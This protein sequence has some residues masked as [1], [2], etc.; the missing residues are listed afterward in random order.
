MPLLRN[1]KRPGRKT[2]GNLQFFEN[3]IRYAW[4]YYIKNKF[5]KVNSDGWV[6][7]QLLKDLK[8]RATN[9]WA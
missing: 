4:Y 5:K 1:F 3:L 2:K 9:Q 8:N 7:E 6:I